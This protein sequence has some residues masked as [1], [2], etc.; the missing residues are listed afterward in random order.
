LKDQATED[1]KRKN[2]SPDINYMEMVDIISQMNSQQYAVAMWAINTRVSEQLDDVYLGALLP[3]I[4]EL[5]ACRKDLPQAFS[6]SCSVTPI[7]KLA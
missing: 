1:I 7:H 3:L 2:S 5:S 4:K 6:G